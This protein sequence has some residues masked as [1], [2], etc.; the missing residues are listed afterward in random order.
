MAKLDGYQALKGNVMAGLQT[1]IGKLESIRRAESGGIES[2]L[3]KI[4]TPGETEKALTKI[5]L[6]DGTEVMRI[7]GE[8]DDA[9]VG[10]AETKGRLLLTNGEGV[11]RLVG[12]GD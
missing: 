8:T 4:V 3:R 11:V 5:W 9:F 1:R 6:S 12:C 7:E 2:I 10:R